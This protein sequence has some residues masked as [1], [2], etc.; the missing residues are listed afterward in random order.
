MVE[1]QE[2]ASHAVIYRA[3]ELRL[4][5]I[6]VIHWLR[7]DVNYKTCVLQDGCTVQRAAA[8]KLSLD[9]K[10]V[11]AREGFSKIGI[12]CGILSLLQARWSVNLHQKSKKQTAGL[13]STYSTLCY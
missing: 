9:L 11:Q 5:H 6:L 13:E 8:V 4:T 12:C 2:Q 3:T 10:F 7:W 1:L